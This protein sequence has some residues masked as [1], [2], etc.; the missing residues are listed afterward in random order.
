MEDN[1]VVVVVGLAKN[2][3]VEPST[4][5]TVG[6]FFGLSFVVTGL[7]VVDFFM[8]VLVISSLDDMFGPC[9]GLGCDVAICCCCWLYGDS[10]GLSCFR[11]YQW[12][13]EGEAPHRETFISLIE[14]PCIKW[15]IFSIFP[16]YGEITTKDHINHFV[17]KRP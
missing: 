2:F 10:D 14:T 11:G 1:I 8:V 9:L 6:K 15:C 4:L 12:R 5:P 17:C 7:N 13:T 16:G 3:L